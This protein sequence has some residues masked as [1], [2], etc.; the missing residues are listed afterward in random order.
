M[1]PMIATALLVANFAFA[2]SAAFAEGGNGGASGRHPW[3]R[4]TV[5]TP[6]AVRASQMGPSGSE[7]DTTIAG[8]AAIQHCPYCAA[9][10]D[11][12]EH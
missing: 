1:R 6:Q 8:T 4:S 3:E 11:N 5:Q 7:P 2:A 10:N 9:R 12:R